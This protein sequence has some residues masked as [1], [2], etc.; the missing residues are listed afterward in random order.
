MPM[1][2]NAEAD[3]KLFV[4]VM[5]VYDVKVAGN[6]LNEVAQMMGPDCT[7]KAITHRLAKLRSQAVGGSSATPPT[8]AKSTTKRAPARST[9]SGS[10]KSKAGGEAT[11]RSRVDAE[12]SGE[13]DDDDE[14]GGEETP[15]KKVKMEMED[16]G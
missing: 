8:N 7:A 13:D 11:K 4:A 14:E 5:K 15:T 16:E 10:A 12:L 3:A 6:K 9:Q 1:V 2:W